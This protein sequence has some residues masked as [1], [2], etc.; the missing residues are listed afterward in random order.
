MSITK[1]KNNHT[2][3]HSDAFTAFTPSQLL[4]GLDFILSHFLL[5]EEDSLFPRKISTYQS[6]NKQFLVRSKEEIIN[7][8]VDSNFVDC[9]INAYPSLTHYKGIQRYRPNLLFIDL[10][11]NDFKSETAFKLALTNTLKKM[12]DK[13]DSHAFP[14]VLWSGNGYH[15]IQPVY[16]PTALENFPEF[17]KF[18]RPSE[19]FLRFAKYY[20][21]NGKADK[22]NNPSFKSC[23]LR[24]PGS[25]NSKYNTK[26]TIVQKWNGYRPRLP[27]EL[28]DEF[29]SYLIQK[30][31]DQ[32]KQRQK[33]LIERSKNKFVGSSSNYYIWIENLIQTPIEDYRK[34]VIDLVLAPYLINIR[35]LSFEESYT[36]IKN[37]LDKCN[38]LQRLD[39]YRNFEYRIEYQLKN[40]MNK[41]IGPMSLEKIKTDPTY[42]ELYQILKNKGAF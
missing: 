29:I 9:R 31:I 21:S 18:D 37:W 13:L 8:F 28:I 12:K 41:Q 22:N 33:I 26:V 2:P 27:I 32:Q 11:K 5:E 23:L 19:Q 25:I 30:K 20:L 36:T 15:I 7:A 34:L 39:N 4:S 38:E 1:I 16:C 10:D 17:E 35:K 40:A 14:T 6:N 42:S 24:I 3:L